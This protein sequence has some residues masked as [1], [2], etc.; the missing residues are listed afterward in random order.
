M[1]LKLSI[2]TPSADVLNV[3]CEEVVVP[4]EAGEIGLLPSHIRLVTALKPGVLTLIRGGKRTH[5]AVSTGYA[6]VESDAVTV[7]TDSCEES[8]AVDVDRAR[9]A[10][11]EA[12]EKLRTLGSDDTSY[13]E[14]ERRAARARARIDASQRRA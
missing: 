11:T 3:E 14:Q 8:S 1:P 12:E 9:R 13:T 6:E 2:V 10:L 4:G 7:L 5:F